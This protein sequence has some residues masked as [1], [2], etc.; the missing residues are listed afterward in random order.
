MNVMFVT[1]AERTRE[2]GI[3]KS[4]GAQQ[5]DILLQFLIESIILSLL[6]GGIGIFLGVATTLLL[7]SFG[8]QLSM[9]GLLL[10][11][12]FSV[13]VGVVFGF[14]PALQASKLDP[15]EALRSE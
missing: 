6:G 5:K 12:G 3:L 1:V 11:F 7:A 2:I 8:A 14:Y 15:V 4:I 10:G 13:L 9:F